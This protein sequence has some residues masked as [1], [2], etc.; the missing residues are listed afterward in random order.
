LRR[1]FG[2][3]GVTLSGETGEVW[4]E[5][6]T[7]ATGAPYRWTNISVDRRLGASWVSAGFGRLEERQSLLGG[8]MGEA[9]GGG[10][11][12]TLFAE[13]ETRR[14]LA[15]GWT[16]GLS[17]RQGWSSFAAGSFRVGAYA[18]DLAKLGVLGSRDRVG[19]RI[20]QPLRVEHGGFATLLPTGY[21]YA[22]GA[23]T[24][25][26]ERLSLAPT[27]REVVGEVSYGANLL[28]GRS[29]L[30][31]NLYYRQQPGHV[32]AANADVG[33]ALRLDLAF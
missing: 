4:H 13:L 23:V 2:R 30:G 22:T 11:S 6:Q 1:T 27:G 33:A 19:L 15:N 28:A 20:A 31:T 24:R 16:A 5:V 7:S 29:W 17:A 32:A 18:F 14:N 8:R 10:G 9:L 25:T 21:D 12:T 3:T 26:L